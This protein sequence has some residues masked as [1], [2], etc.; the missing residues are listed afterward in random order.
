MHVISKPSA[1]LQQA[2]DALREVGL[3][4]PEA[5]EEFPWGHSALKVKKKTFVFLY[6]DAD[7]LSVSTK[8]P[9]SLDNALMLPFAQPT[10]YGL[11][12]A[13]WVTAS[14]D[15]KSAIPVPLLNE[16]I[17][18]SY[19]AIAPKKLAQQAVLR[20]PAEKRPAK[21]PAKKRS[22]QTSAKKP[23]A[24]TPAKKPSAKAPAK[25]SKR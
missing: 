24:K 8:L 18:E 11:G 17:L 4:L 13:G 1:K 19:R 9:I 20:A 10:G 14:F 23:P 5:V 15:N 22:T 16:W 7:S 3:A 12:K 2:M 25:K 6:A 21:A